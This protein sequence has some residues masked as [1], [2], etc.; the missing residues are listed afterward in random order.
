MKKP[1]LLSPAGNLS[2]LKTAVLYGADAVYAG[3]EEFSLRASAGNFSLDELALGVE[4][5]HS[6]GVRVY[7]ACNTVPHE[8]ELDRFP[9]YVKALYDMGADAVIVSD[10]GLI[11]LTKEHAPGLCVHLSTQTN[12]MNSQACRFWHGLGVSRIVLARE[13]SL[14]EVSGIRRAVPETLELEAFVHGAMC[15]SHS[16]RCLL[17]SA[18]TGR[19]ANRGD[20]AQPCRWRYALVEEKRPGQYF[21]VCEDDTGTFILNSKDLCMIEHLPALIAAG[22][23]SLKIEGRA[24]SE[25]YVACV[26]GA[27]RSAIDDCFEDVDRYLA[28][29]KEYYNEVCKVSHRPYHTGFYFTGPDAEK[30]HTSS[31]GYIR[32]YDVVG[33]VTSYDPATKTARVVQKNRFVCGEELEVLSPLWEPVSFRVTY[34]EDAEGNEIMSAPHPE[35]EVRIRVPSPLAA[36][37]F[38]RRERQI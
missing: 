33:L 23:D 12:T 15:V 24:K 2:K 27:Y 25:Y 6:R 36:G 14:S 22:V 38:L 28:K 30:Q 20:C 16:G 4:F 26:T 21:P 11:M 19:D 13:L 18:M 1:E 32:S 34:M 3:G 10:P 35:M 29:R 37:S 5:A 31:S 17:S 9:E 8:E 7:V